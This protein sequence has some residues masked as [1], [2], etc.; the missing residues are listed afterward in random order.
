MKKSFLSL[1]ILALASVAAIAQDFKPVSGSKTLELQAASPFASGRPFSIDNI[2]ARYFIADDMAVRVQFGIFVDNDTDQDTAAGKVLKDR[3]RLF[4]F[5]IKPGI[6]KHFEGTDRLSPYVGAELDIAIQSVSSVDESVGPNDNIRTTTVRGTGA[7][8]DGYF[9][10]GVNLV[11][12]ADY[13]ISKNLYLGAE[14]GWGIQSV[15]LSTIKTELSGF[16]GA[17]TPKDFERGGTLSVGTNFIGAFRL[18][19]AF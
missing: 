9:R 15:S 14:V 16:E 1:A 11:G 3:E 17:T 10:F 8:G 18:G 13:Y 19:W 5:N 2:R 6:E 4:N 12:G 7:K